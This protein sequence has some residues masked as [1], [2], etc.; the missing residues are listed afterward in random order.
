MLRRRT[1]AVVSVLI[2]TVLLVACGEPDEPANVGQADDASPTIPDDA[3]PAQVSFELAG[4]H[5]VL[6]SLNGANV[7]RGASITISFDERQGHGRTTCNDYYLNPYIAATTAFSVVDGAID[8]E[9]CPGAQGALESAYLEALRGASSYI[10]DADHLELKNAAGDTVLVFTRA[11]ESDAVGSPTPTSPPTSVET[12]SPAATTPTPEAAAPS[13]TMPFVDVAPLD[14]PNIDVTIYWL[15]LRFDPEGN[16]P[17]LELSFVAGPSQ[18]GGGPDDSR[19]ELQYSVVDATNPTT[20]VTLRLWNRSDWDAWVARDPAADPISAIFHMF[21]DS[22]CSKREEVA[23]ENGQAVIYSS[24]QA[25][26]DPVTGECPGGQFDRFLAHVF[27]GDT[28]VTVNAPFLLEAPTPSPYAAPYNT[29]E[30][31]RAIVQGLQPREP[32]TNPTP[33]PTSATSLDDPGSLVLQAADLPSR[34]SYGDDGCAPGREC[35]TGP[36]G[37]SGEGDYDELVSAAGLFLSA[38]YQYEHV[39]FSANGTPDPNIEPPT[40]DTFAL[41]CVQECDPAAILDVAP[42]LLR[43]NGHSDATD[44]GIVP[45]LGDAA[46]LYE[47]NTLVLG[48]VTPGYA[49]VWRDGPAVAMLVAGGVTGETG[50]SIALDLA[51]KQAARMQQ[52]VGQ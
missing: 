16:L 24:H 2:L 52:A 23:L 19:G 34:Y 32:V 13:P 21:W 29:L 43:Y 15:G 50:Q 26:A 51:S 36:S 28:V 8:E 14:D 22:P 6:T 7:D 17:P 44:T 3:T 12:P 39:G 31:M 33:L 11:D 47:V 41:V 37:F 48:Q 30:G 40:I 18:P 42:E 20:G 49:V 5:W 10:T 38:H 25:P 1:A 35:F 9:G 4:T 45:D 27:L 46:I